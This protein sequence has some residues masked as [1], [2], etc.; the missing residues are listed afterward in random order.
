MED[1]G[2][3]TTGA[4]STAQ[5]TPFEALFRRYYG[6]L[7]GFFLNRGLERADCE[8]LA[9]ETLMSAYRGYDTFRGEASD[10]TWL[11]TIAGNIWKNNRRES[12][13][14]RRDGDTLSL[15]RSPEVR[16]ETEVRVNEREKGSA[17]D[18]LV[19]GLVGAEQRRELWQAIP[20]LAPQTRR[21]LLLH[22][23]GLKYREVA[24][25]LGVEVGT[26]KSLV[27]QAKMRLR[28]LIRAESPDLFD[29]PAPR[30]G[31]GGGDDE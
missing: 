18:A 16:H 25:I 15:D 24:E 27:S 28:E 8:D 23:A 5:R 7:V 13:A 6:P 12:K 17:E 30:A 22:L 19:N 21:A 29:G 9:Q 26:V 10:A 20:L 14:Q 1:R 31:S 11:F 2:K 4:P 3:S